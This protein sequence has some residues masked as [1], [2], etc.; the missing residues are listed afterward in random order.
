M[1]LLTDTVRNHRSASK[2]SSLVL[3][4]NGRGKARVAGGQLDRVPH[5]T[6]GQREEKNS[7]VPRTYV[8]GG[9]EGDGVTF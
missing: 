5:V 3:S 1:V 2:Q 9:V 4:S 8:V 6:K 7:F